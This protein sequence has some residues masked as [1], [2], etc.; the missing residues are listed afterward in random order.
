[1]HRN[2][3]FSQTLDVRNLRTKSVTVYG[4]RAE[5]K[6]VVN[7]DLEKGLNEIILKNISSVVER[8]SLR[9]DANGTVAIQ[10]VQYQETPL[11]RNSSESKKIRE[12]EQQKNEEDLKR[13]SLEDEINVLKK[14]VEVLDGV[15]GQISRNMVGTSEVADS[16]KK[17]NGT[18][19]T[20]TPI[21]SKLI[22][23]LRL[24]KL[25]YLGNTVS[26]IKSEIRQKTKQLDEL[27]QTI[28]SLEREIDKMRCSFEYDCVERNV[29]VTIN[30]EEKESVELY[31]T[32][33]VYCASW[34]PTYDI[35]VIMGGEEDKIDSLKLCYYGIIEQNTG[36][37]WK[38]AEIVLSTAT[39]SV[40][41]AVP[42]LCTLAAGFQK[43]FKESRKRNASSLRKPNSA[44]S[45]EDM[46]FGSFDYND[47]TDAIALQKLTAAAAALPASDIDL[48][49]VNNT[50][51][52]P[53]SYF[54]ISEPTT[55]CSDGCEHKVLVSEVDVEPRFLHETVPAHAQAAYVTAIATNTSELTFLPGPASV[56]LNTSFIAKTQ[57][58]A[59]LP[60]GEF[61]CNLG[62]D[63]SVK[64][65]YK[66]SKRVKEQIG[67][68]SK[69]ALQTKIQPIVIRNTKANRSLQI[70][71]RE[72]VPKSTDDRIKVTL[73]SPD[74]RA[75]KTAKLNKE[76]N[77]EWTLILAPSE[78]RELAVKW[79][80]EYPV[81]ETITY[82]Q[83]MQTAA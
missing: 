9:V 25:C 37:D 57:L 68:V 7:C 49:T 33:Q 3:V 78:H 76:H 67:F 48:S 30:A 21:Y 80:I 73:L 18:T 74:L 69:S 2:Q 27:F 36:E 1:M 38:C 77:L 50:E 16:E 34:R 6:K 41:G 19:A 52:L 55:V 63:P 61:S 71:I 66:P 47:I 75:L 43:Q 70:T 60:G 23:A 58:G 32:Y 46:G 62:I 24:Y 20:T 8:Q 4:D 82:K 44:T 26:D 28:D 40:G 22:D 10:Q 83:V 5:V 79:C 12:I 54:S 39:P 45:D 31:V 72:H 81:N 59:V 29:C 65:E 53:C 35:R 11:D 14:R 13:M 64:V 56:Y 51:Q 15:A 17:L 42:P